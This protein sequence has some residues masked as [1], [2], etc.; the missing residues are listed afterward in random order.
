MCTVHVTT[1]Q[2]NTICLNV[3]LSLDPGVAELHSLH[4]QLSLTCRQGNVGKNFT[5]P[6]IDPFADT[7]KS[8]DETR[9][10]LWSYMPAIKPMTCPS[11]YSFRRS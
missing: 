3:H 9:K 8:A 5:V 4:F 6:Y 2:F 1:E 10:V 11:Q 7:A